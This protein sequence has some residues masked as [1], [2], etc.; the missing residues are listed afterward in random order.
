MITCV[1]RLLCVHYPHLHQVW[2]THLSSFLLPNIV[3]G[4]C[5]MS[6]VQYEFRYRVWRWSSRYVGLYSA[7]LVLLNCQQR[8][9]KCVWTRPNHSACMY[10]P[11]SAD[12]LPFTTVHTLCLSP[13]GRVCRV[14][15]NLKRVD[16]AGLWLLEV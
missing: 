9:F 15:I 10:L 8:E 13:E 16:P 14:E 2:S 11:A 5:R 1:I 6:L 12:I 4:L 3:N 7:R